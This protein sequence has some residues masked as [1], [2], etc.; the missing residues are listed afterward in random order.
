MEV[1][2]VTEKG[3]VLVARAS[4]PG[5]TWFWIVSAAL[6]LSV[7]ALASIFE[8]D[9][10]MFLLYPG[11]LLTSPFWPEGAHSGSG[12]AASAVGFYAVFVFG[13]LVCWAALFRLLLSLIDRL[14]RR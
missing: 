3:A 6:A 12:G 13:N 7:F 14:R 10:S 5:A 9:F 8:S 1:L 2:H 11:A 4:S